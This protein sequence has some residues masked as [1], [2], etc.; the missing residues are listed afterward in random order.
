MLGAFRKT[1]TNRQTLGYA[2][3]AGG[4]FG[5]LFGYV[6]SSQQI[7]T[8]V[9]DLGH[10]FP[11]AFAAIAV[12]V[13]VA[14]FLNSRLV[15][16]LGMRVISHGALIGCV[17]VAAIMFVAARLHM[18][19]LV[20]VHDVVGAD[21]VLVRP[22]VCELHRAGDGAAGPIAGTASSLYGSITTLLGIGAAPRRPG[23]RRHAAAVRDRLFCLHAGS[24]RRRAGGGKGTVVQVA[25]W[26][27]RTRA[28]R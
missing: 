11:L 25:A 13:A 1:L 7:F 14:G 5:A 28:Q 15:G 2:L 27:R 17:V 24:T 19:P 3:A 8:G 12:G 22:D 20:G 4:I 9:Y 23:L 6:F 16:R 21:D 26:P 18:L 10:Y